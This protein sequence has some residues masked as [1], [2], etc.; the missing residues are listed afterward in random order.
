MLGQVPVNQRMIRCRVTAHQF[1]RRPVFL[2]IFRVERQPRQV[3]VLLGEV[4]MLSHGELAVV[5]AH[6]CPGSTTAAVA[7]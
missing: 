5:I 2:A 3:L 6:R 7:Q 1:H 4:R